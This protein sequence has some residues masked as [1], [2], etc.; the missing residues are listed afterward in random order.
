MEK[1]Q[2]QELEEIRSARQSVAA[3]RQTLE[4]S[5]D[6]SRAF[7]KRVLDFVLSWRDWD[8]PDLFETALRRE[9]LLT[10]GS[11]FA[12][13]LQEYEVKFSRPNNL[14]V[15]ADLMIADEMK[16]KE[17]EK[18]MIE[19]LDQEYYESAMKKYGAQWDKELRLEA[20]EEGRNDGWKEGRDDGWKEGRNDGWKEGQDAGRIGECVHSIRCFLTTRFPNEPLSANY[21]YVLETLRDMPTLR[22][23]Q[24]YCFGASSMQNVETFIESKIKN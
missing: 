11:L 22:S 2:V 23:I 13:D 24:R 9:T 6:D 12:P 17:Y 8:S 4:K 19:L 5:T 20:W 21:D 16:D 14:V 15:A 10:R 18:Q 3:I 1:E 7:Q